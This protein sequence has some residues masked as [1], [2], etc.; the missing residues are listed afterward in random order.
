[1]RAEDEDIFRPPSELAATAHVRTMEQYRSM[2]HRSVKQPE[3]FWSEIAGELKWD[4]EDLDVLDTKL[5][6]NFDPKQ[7]DVFVRWFE[8]AKTNMAYNCLEL[9]IERGLGDSPALIFEANDELDST[10]FTF[11]ELLVEVSTVSKFLVAQGVRKGDRVVMYL[12]MIPALP[13]ACLACA[14]IGAVHSVVFA[15]YSAKSLAQRIM[16]CQAKLVI[17]ASASRRG[18]KIIPLKKIVDDALEICAAVP[19]GSV[20]ERVLVKHNADL[21]VAI[22]GVL[23]RKD[24]HVPFNAN[25]DMWW[26]ESLAD[27]RMDGKPAPIE[28]LDSLDTAFIL[29][30]SG[31]T[32][33]PKGIVHSVGGYQTY[34][35]A[36]SKFVFDLK[37]GQDVVFCTADI[38]WITGHSYSLYGPLLNGCSTILFEGH[39]TYPDPSVWW[40]ICDKHKVTVF[41]TSPTALR[42]LQGYGEDPVRRTSRASLR[43]LGTVGEPISTETW[44]WYREVVG[45]DT[46]PIVD[47]WW[48]TET[49]GHVITPLPGA[50]PLKPASAGFPFFGVVPAL[51]DPKD[52]T[53]IQGEG[54]GCLCFKGPP[55]PGIFNDVHGAHERYESSYFKIFEGGYYASGDGARRDADGYYYITGRLDDVMNVSGHRI[56]TAEVESALVQHPSCIEAAVVSI[57]HEIKG[58]TIVAFVILDPS[59]KNEQSTPA[60]SA[61][62]ELISNVRMEIGPFAA[63]E[64]VIVV[65]DL[66]KTRSGK[67][68]RRVLRKIATGNVD[69]FGDLSALADA[70]VLESVIRAELQTR[71]A[72]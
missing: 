69:D 31:S 70:T 15:G 33:R 66:P 36:T 24:S 51:L 30:T 60:E 56:G 63:P 12:P 37:P 45:D 65:N 13:I 53:E 43:I 44:L 55:W 71:S 17:T 34:T 58:E 54:E 4:P 11:K 64:R 25:R 6:Y 14:R 9:Q 49:G 18:E 72:R 59:R 50:T 38:G 29:Y 40:R 5:A 3:T 20:V 48:Q 46:L 42:T 61:E 32:G 2:Y 67:I 27:Y 21:D 7:G 68:M 26:N 57:G 10:T 28:Y 39:P 47:T 19:G 23:H 62:R 35:Y 1:M 16:D 52:G 41:Y 22:D 8:G